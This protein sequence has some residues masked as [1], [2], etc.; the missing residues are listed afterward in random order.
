MKKSTLLIIV[1]LG[2]FLLYIL[3]KLFFLLSYSPGNVTSYTY[4][5]IKYKDDLFYQ[6]TDTFLLKHPEYRD[7]NTMSEKDTNLAHLRMVTLYFKEK[8]EERY[9]ISISSGSVRYIYKMKDGRILQSIDKLSDEDN[10]RIKKRINIIWDEI[11]KMIEN[12][13]LPD[14][15]KYYNKK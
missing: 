4:V 13:N 12:A 7:P 11:G 6:Y 8:P 9:D 2:C 14:S 5:P 15:V 10:E 3:Y 1:V